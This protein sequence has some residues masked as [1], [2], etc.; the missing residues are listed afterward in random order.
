M[1]QT[2]IP[3][4]K[5]KPLGIPETSLWCGGSWRARQDS[6]PRPSVPK[7]DALSTE[8]LARDGRRGRVRSCGTH[9]AVADATTLTVEY[10]LTTCRVSSKK[11]LRR[12]G[13]GLGVPSSAALWRTT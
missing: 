6:N 13:S 4:E 2:A 11:A 1:A 5:R 3:S 12:D 9:R 7:T 10:H 8:L